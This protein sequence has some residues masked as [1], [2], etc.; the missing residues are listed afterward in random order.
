MITAELLTWMNESEKE[1][2][3]EAKKEIAYLEYLE[4]LPL[5]K[6]ALYDYRSK[7]GLNY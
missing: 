2:L 4:S 3:K 7:K 5:F 1:L 6:E